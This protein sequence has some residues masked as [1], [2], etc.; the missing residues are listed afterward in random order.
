[1]PHKSVRPHSEKLMPAW[2]NG[3]SLGLVKYGATLG[4]S[5]AE[6]TDAQAN[7]A[8]GAA[9]LGQQTLLAEYAQGFTRFKQAALYATEPCPAWPTGFTIPMGMPPVSHA[10]VIPLLTLLIARIKKHPAYIT[11]MGEEMG[12]EGVNQMLMPAEVATTKPVLKLRI[13]TGGHPLVMWK[14]Q[15][16]ECIEIWVDRG[17]GKGRV[18]LAIDTMPDYLDQTPLPAR[19]TSAVWTYQ[20]IYHLS[21]S[22]AGQWSD[23]VQISVMGA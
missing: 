23:E 22:Q 9:V 5:P 21:G 17:D 7:C 14:K 10:G 8:F 12:I 18:F 15:S 3:L 11:Q 16:M 6:I 2:F 1:M 19:N 13:D 20:A 4:L